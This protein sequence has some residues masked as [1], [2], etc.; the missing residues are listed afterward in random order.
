MLKLFELE[1]NFSEVF[2]KISS[3]NKY[4]NKTGNPIII[5]IN[6]NDLITK[7]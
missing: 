2:S 1:N 7:I 5:V 3:N 6:N 4:N